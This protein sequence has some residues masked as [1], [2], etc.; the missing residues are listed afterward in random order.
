MK[1][2][3]LAC[4]MTLLSVAAFGQ[5]NSGVTGTVT[6][7]SG[8]IIP[9]VQVTLTDTKTNRDLTTTTNDQGT[10]TFANIQP[11]TGFKL[12][13]AGQGFQT[14]VLND[15]A[16]GIGRVETYNAQLTAGQVTETVEVTSTTGE[17]T[18]NTTDPSIG[19]VI[20]ERQL[21][22]L[23]VQ[24]RDNPAA[25]IG[26]QPGVIGNNV[27]T[28]NIN[29]VGSVTGARA[30]Q[31]NITVDGID[32][33][34]VATG[35]AFVTIG[36][37]PIDSVQ[38]FRAITTNPNA[39]E[40]RSSGGQIQLGTRSGSNQFHG[41]LREFYRGEKFAAN[42]F[43]NNANGIA[44]PALQR[45]Q[46]GGSL[47]GP[48]P[49]FNFG[50]HAPGD[51]WFK[52][53]KDRLFFFFDYE[54]R[55][56]DSEIS[57]SRVVPLQHVREGRIA[58]LNNAP[59][60]T[61]IPVLQ[62][63]L[64]TNP[65]CISFLS[66]SDIANL[67]PRQ[68]G[69]N[70]SLLSF[71]SG[72][73]PAPNDLSGGNG[74]NTGLFRFNAP[75]TLSNNT[76]TTRVDGNI[77]DTQRAFGRLTLTRN[78]QTNT[79]QLFPGDEDAEKLLDD[80]YQLVGGHTWVIT[81]NLTNQ[82]TVGI[83]RQIWEFPVP[84]SAAYPTIFTFGPFQAPFADISF[85]NRD[86]IVPTF[87]DD[88]T[89]AT[90]S[91]QFFFGGQFKPIRQK[92]TLIN[93]FNFATIGLGGQTTALNSTLRPTNLR[94]NSA[95]AN[96][97]FDAAFAFLLG[98]VAS[99]NTNYVYDPTG[100]VQPLGTGKK[101]DYAYNEYELYVQDNW[102]LRNDLT[103]NLGVR[104]HLYPAPYEKNGFQAGTDVDFEDLVAQRAANAAAG[105][106][107]DDAV[108]LLSYDLIG[109]ANNG[110][111]FYKTEWNNFAPRIGFAYNPSFKGGVLGA[112]FGDR[113]TV[114]RGGWAKTYDRVGGALSFIEDQF[115][116]IFDNAAA[117]TFGNINP[118]T[119]LLNDPR[120]TG[121]GSLPV[122]NTAPTITRPFTPDPNGLANFQFNYAIAQNFKIP[123][124]YQWS[125]GV[126]REL[127]WNHLID[128]SYVGRRGRR[129]LA[130]SDA[131]Q[132]IDFKDPQ[133]GQFMLA[134]FNAMQ[135]QQ[136]GGVPIT[137]QP[138][139]E[140]QVGRA[141][142]TNY[143]LTC[144]QIALE[145]LDEVI[146]NCTD[147]VF[148]LAP[149][150][151]GTGGTADLVNGLFNNFLLDSNVGLG[152]QFAVNAYIT[153]QGRSN[154]DAMLVSLR[155]RFSS[156][157][158]YDV[159]YTWSHAI[160]NQSSVTNAVQEA[161]IYNVLDPTAGRGNADF[162]IRHLFNANVVWELPFGRG[163]TFFGGANRWADA[164]IGGWTFAGIFTARTGLPV[165]SFSGAW[166]VTVFT[167]DNEGVP[168][169]LVGP[170]TNFA[171]DIRDTPGG[172]QYFA[173]P[174][175]VQ[176]NFRYPR[177][178][179]VGNRNVFRSQG[180]WN[181]DA[182]VSKKFAMPWEGHVLTFRAEAYNLFNKNFFGPPNL[183]FQSTEF[184]LIT[185]SQ[186]DPRV[187]QFALRYDF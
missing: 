74:V 31:G 96:S 156:G 69:V 125:F 134:A 5:T 16:L 97:T 105:I 154:Y 132:I 72:R 168:S 187:I 80:S 186:S 111:P 25:L 14:F 62:V 157:I 155:K 91:H 126:Q 152:R 71:L 45:H 22:E 138:W 149:D 183:D 19:N 145:F 176:A 123:Y 36:N 77:S 182:V 161:L 61:S 162:D 87:R 3:F 164:V 140:N 15:I 46:F 9:G 78:Q 94:P 128:V 93:D 102:R 141:A 127:P 67:D 6:D 153:N 47:S 109:K 64:D 92:S 103:V 129:L 150:L 147:L 170:N 32:S 50:D 81:P 73:Y 26:L 174:D 158:Q 166:P 10:Y 115:S 48:L 24:L 27:G 75:V 66:Q 185:T 167:A 136:A 18:L 29:R 41:S 58:Y 39:S 175:A 33:N 116:Y 124:S 142:I 107:G 49:F 181:V 143:G 159:N 65:Q 171:V 56:D 13:F 160:D 165:T 20:N 11:G 44:R 85:Q 35:Q 84:T 101:R 137:A 76:Y 98:R 133:S 177:H 37:L 104:W 4:L 100:N 169:V 21:R 82:A 108:P 120:F 99:L 79:E 54:G 59:G 57:V 112:L 122:Q 172:I 110:R 23:P 43:F 12:S 114:L 117:Q 130:Q 17:A 148:L 60:C 8:A 28:G 83:S 118:R 163:R 113:K 38:E 88:V 42:T 53:G 173:D 63:R 70:Q 151:V 7:P 40:G 55:R 30:D 139:V 86:V 144:P 52:S 95:T 2:V 146:N 180:Y 178:G 135:A 68:T 106:S 1:T 179:E 121:I 131:N 90:G 51:P 34:D 119:A 89:W 184:G